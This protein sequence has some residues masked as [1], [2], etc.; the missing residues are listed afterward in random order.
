[1]KEYMYLLLLNYRKIIIALIVGSLLFLLYPWFSWSVKSDTVNIKYKFQYQISEYI[2]DD[3]IITCEPP[4]NVL[5]RMTLGDEIP[6]YY[7]YKPSLFSEK[8]IGSFSSKLNR[9]LFDEV[10]F[11]PNNSDLFT[12]TFSGNFKKGSLSYK[13]IDQEVV[14]LVNEAEKSIRLESQEKKEKFFRIPF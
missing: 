14:D 2:K 8:K 11:R 9:C 5:K 7:S 10:R 1:M 13:E 4:E 6:Y 3:L 12:Y